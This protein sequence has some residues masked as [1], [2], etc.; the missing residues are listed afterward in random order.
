MTTD[1]T[2]KPES[3]SRSGR[4]I[5]LACFGALSLFMYVS[6]ILKILKYGP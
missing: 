6:I 1:R 4:W 5:L 2:I 3:K